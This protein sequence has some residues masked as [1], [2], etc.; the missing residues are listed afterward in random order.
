MPKIFFSGTSTENSL[1]ENVLEN[2]CVMISYYD[3]RYNRAST[4]KRLLKLRMRQIAAKRKDRRPGS[5]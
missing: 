4:I 1:P 2:P 5:E 3:I